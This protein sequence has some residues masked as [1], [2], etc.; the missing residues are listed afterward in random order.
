MTDLSTNLEDASSGQKNIKITALGLL[1]ACL[2][3][4]ALFIPVLSGPPL[5]D[6]CYLLAWWSHSLS[7]GFFSQDM[8]AQVQAPAFDLRDGQNFLGNFVQVLTAAATGTNCGAIRLLQVTVHLANA[9]LLAFCIFKGGKAISADNAGTEL[10]FAMTALAGA[11]LFITYPLSPESVGWLGGIAVEAA[12]LLTLLTTVNILQS[13]TGPKRQTFNAIML[14][15]APWISVKV[16][17]LT[18]LVFFM[19]NPVAKKVGR[20]V[21]VAA[22]LSTLIALSIYTFTIVSNQGAVPETIKQLRIEKIDLDKS[23]T[24]AQNSLTLSALLEAS[25]ANL[26]AIVLPVNRK[27]DERYNKV[28][29]RFYLVL[30]IEAVIF[31]IAF[32]L[33]PVLRRLALAAALS[34]AVG[35]CTAGGIESG[36]LYGAHWLY[37]TLPA[38][39]L[40]MALLATSPL[41]LEGK[42]KFRGGSKTGYIKLFCA[43]I[44]ICLLGYLFSERTYKQCMSYKSNGK[45]WKVIQATIEDSGRR[46]TSPFIVARNLPPALSVAPM[47]SPFSPQLIDTQSGLPRTMS[48]SAGLFKDAIKKGHYHGLALHYRQQY[49]SFLPTEFEIVNKPFGPILGASQ[50]ADLLSPPLSYYQGTVSL[51]KNAG[52]LH[53]VS[54]TKMGPAVRMQCFGLSPAQD[55]FLCIEAKIQKVDK[56]PVTDQDLLELHWL[57]NWQGDWDGRDRKLTNSGTIY[58]GQFHRYYFPL[59]TLAWLTSGLPTDIMLGF[60]RQTAIDLKSVSVV[61][62]GDTGYEHL[63]MPQI[64]ARANHVQNNNRLYF[65]H[66]CFDYPDAP[67]FGLCAVYGSQN[68]LD[69]NYDVSSIEGA[70]AAKIE[71]SRG[72]ETLTAV[73]KY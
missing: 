31:F 35:V 34:L 52:V 11:I 1:L 58:Y 27:I 45:L 72:L 12:V 16:L 38:A 5:Y 23:A 71:I 32:A 69:I 42:G 21:L 22:G 2:A 64:R 47:I 15:L 50:I 7:S 13:K 56:L 36:N 53:L 54:Q 62:N 73:K 29:R 55:D 41:Y 39:A 17:P 26:E 70:R 8:L 33:N 37:P 63:A 66:Y 3:G 19:G 49:E 4:L 30:I 67:E 61:R 60:P 59:R 65:S 6:E 28:L 20:P 48:L 14:V 10:A 25:R 51:D 24:Q 9:M 18:V 44:F 40:L 46:R 68:S 57:T 43:I